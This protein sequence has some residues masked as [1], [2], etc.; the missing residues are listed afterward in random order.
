MRKKT[1]LLLIML[2]FV[3]TQS[4]AIGMKSI[5][6]MRQIQMDNY[7]WMVDNPKGK[8]KIRFVRNEDKSS[9]TTNKPK[10]FFGK[11]KSVVNMIFDASDN[12]PFK[13]EIVREK[14]KK[15]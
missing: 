1:L 12:P 3:I 9:D 15:N 5:D 11:L 4:K 13:V 2:L 8:L 6:P 7:E 14:E 10:G